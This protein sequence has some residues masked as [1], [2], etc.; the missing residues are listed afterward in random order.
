MTKNFSLL[1]SLIID[2]HFRLTIPSGGLAED[3]FINAKPSS[4][5]YDAYKK[6]FENPDSKAFLPFDEGIKNVIDSEQKFA[7]FFPKRVFL[8]YPDNIKCQAELAFERG[9]YFESMTLP[10]NSQYH[11]IFAKYII[12]LKSRGILDLILGKYTKDQY[13][14]ETEPS[15][16]LGFEKLGSMFVMLMSAIALAIIVLCL[17][18][19]LK[20]SVNVKK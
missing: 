6:F 11:K 5:Y 4:D 9:P 16:L 10:K 18:K 17:E 13:V 7:Y 14:C 12:W 15:Y 1:V 3:F 2:L 8:N 19:K 20:R